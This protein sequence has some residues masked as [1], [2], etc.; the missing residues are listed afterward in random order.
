MARPGAFLAL[1]GDDRRLL[2]EAG[3]RLVAAWVALR[4]FPFAR[5]VASIRPRPGVAMARDAGLVRRVR[6]AVEV[7]ARRLPTVLTCLPQALAASWMLQARG[8]G[9]RL[10]Y[11]VAS[12][13]DEG[14]EAHAWVELDGMPVIGRRGADRFTPLARF[15]LEG[16]ARP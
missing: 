16:Q 8:L 3:L 7:A 2:V 5:V 1:N 11:G 12:S 13:G 10:H 4:I 9:P 6:W 14:F 15:P